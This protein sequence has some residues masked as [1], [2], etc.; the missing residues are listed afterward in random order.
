MRFWA[1]VE[2]LAAM[3][4]FWWVAVR[5]ETFLLLTTSLFVAPLLL[6]R[7]DESTRLGVKW[8]GE[9]VFRPRAMNDPRNSA[10]AERWERRGAA[11][12]AAIGITVGLGLGY[13]AAKLY[14]VGHEG[15][16]A[17]GRGTGVGLTI[18][19]LA[20]A[21]AG[22]AARAGTKGAPGVAMA[23]AAVLGPAGV[24]AT[25]V[26]AGAPAAG[27][28]ALISRGVGDICSGRRGR[29]G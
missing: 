7:S 29:R 15:W 26:V 11:I 12:G 4:V 8:L 17:L 3:A 5:Y 19:G 18:S 28:A 25:A 2:T 21:I 6:L 16:S 20:G 14:L 24:L 1:I 23:I 10:E 27:C 13:P 22:G 9:G